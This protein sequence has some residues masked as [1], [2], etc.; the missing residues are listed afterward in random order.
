MACKLLVAN[1]DGGQLVVGCCIGQHASFG[2][3]SHQIL[4]I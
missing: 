3:L 4:S 2:N 1:S